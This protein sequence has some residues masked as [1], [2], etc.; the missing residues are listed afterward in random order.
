MRYYV[1]ST[2]ELIT[3]ANGYQYWRPKVAQYLKANAVWSTHVDETKREQWS[4]T[5]IEDTGRDPWDDEAGALADPDLLIVSQANF[6]RALGAD[7]RT[8]V[9]TWL[10]RAGVTEDPRTTEEAKAV[11]ERLS[12]QHG[13]R[14]R[15][16]D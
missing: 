14:R 4:I 7:G 6:R 8:A 2:Q 1:L 16:P 10:T 3:R 13:G 5:T 15:F 11:Y 12:D 9:N